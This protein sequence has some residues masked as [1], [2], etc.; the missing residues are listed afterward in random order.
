M[1][2]VID[3]LALFSLPDL[4]TAERF[5]R[6]ETG[7]K[8]S[9]RKAYLTFQAGGA[10]FAAPA[11]DVHGT[12]PR[13]HVDRDALAG[14]LCLGSVRV[15]GVRIPVIDAPGLLGL[16]TARERANPEIVVI[17][18]EGEHLLG[19]AVDVICRI[20]TFGEQQLTTVPA[21]LGGGKSALGL[22]VTEDDGTQTYVIRVEYLREDPDLKSIA[23]LSGP[24]TETD[25]RP[26]KKGDAAA[27]NDTAKQAHDDGR[28]ASNTII[29]ERKRYVVFEACSTFAIPI[30][31]IIRIL[32]PPK[33]IT[34]FPD[35]GGG[36]LG[37][38]SVDGQ[39]TTLVCL[40]RYL[41]LGA[42]AETDK[43][44][45]LLA[46]DEDR[47]I[48]ILVNSVDG[49]ETSTWRAENTEPSAFLEQ[50]VKL[51]RPEAQVVLPRLDVDALSAR[52]ARG[53]RAMSVFA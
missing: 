19:L 22:M 7:Y 30:E 50:M 43:R 26:A 39:P 38:F 32:E 48:G 4:P 25:G 13:Q 34:P 28:P 11:I 23:G 42:P 8:V 37:L 21:L 46:G 51:G 6:K 15:N 52:I 17:S 49:I 24:V 27:R 10:R 36:I 12:L 45:V 18:F 20:A 14:G 1:I 3:P 44:R 33:K 47:Q 40:C 29:H 2:N 5:R 53:N 31:K 35:T 16:G 9:G 41:H